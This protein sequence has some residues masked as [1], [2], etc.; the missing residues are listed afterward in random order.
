MSRLQ[1]PTSEIFGRSSVG[2]P[3]TSVHLVTSGST[4]GVNGGTQKR[5]VSPGGGIEL[6]VLCMFNQEGAQNY[7]FCVCLTRRGHRIISSVY[8]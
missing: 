7:G 8:V 1:S 4:E 5:D 3:E 2:F 6:S